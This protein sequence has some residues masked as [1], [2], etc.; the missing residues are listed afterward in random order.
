MNTL[1]RYFYSSQVFSKQILNK[2]LLY[3]DHWVSPVGIANRKNQ[4]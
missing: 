3:V 4:D 2:C 1:L